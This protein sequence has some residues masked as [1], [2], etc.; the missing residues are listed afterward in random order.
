M[1]RNAEDQILG[2][3]R[4]QA[5]TLPLSYIL[6]SSFSKYTF[7][8]YGSLS[9]LLAAMG[10]EKKKLTQL[11]RIKGLLDVVLHVFNPRV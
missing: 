6:Y 10:K 5:S 1:T 8:N 7:Q 3:H 4:F 9:G 11:L 2:H